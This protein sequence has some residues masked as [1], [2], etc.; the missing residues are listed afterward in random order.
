MR[1]TSLFFLIGLVSFAIF[2]GSCQYGFADGP[3]PL[4]ATF[5][6]FQEG[7]SAQTFTDGGVTLSNLN[8][9]DNGG[10]NPTFSVES[11]GTDGTAAGIDI[12][13][14]PWYGPEPSPQPGHINILKLQATYEGAWVAA[15]YV[16]FEDHASYHH[17][18]ISDM[19]FDALQLV[20]SGSYYD[21]AV[22]I[23][24]DYVSV[25]PIP[26]PA[27]LLLLGLGMMLLRKRR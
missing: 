11:I 10:F 5:D 23:L 6:S 24:I 22:Y 7:Y 8:Y 26:E 9:Y 19:R 4:T 12:F 21:G 20:A 3:A 16:N 1:K 25:T 2:P 27:T 14:P 15:T 17:M 18:E 13:S